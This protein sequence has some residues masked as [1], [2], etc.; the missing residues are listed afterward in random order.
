MV[1]TTMMMNDDMMEE[2]EFENEQNNTENNENKFKVRNYKF[3]ICILI[4]DLIEFS[5]WSHL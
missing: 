5:E 4:N 3:I 2:G 1:T